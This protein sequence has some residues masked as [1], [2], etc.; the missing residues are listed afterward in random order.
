[1]VAWKASTS[2]GSSWAQRLVICIITLGQRWPSVG[3]MKYVYYNDGPVLAQRW[4]I[5]VWLAECW[6]LF[7]WLKSK[8]LVNVKPTVGDY[9][10]PMNKI[11]LGQ[12]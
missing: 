7:Q 10:G 8:C 9:V 11:T 6:H 1:M 5:V 4:F 3:P 12:R 2:V